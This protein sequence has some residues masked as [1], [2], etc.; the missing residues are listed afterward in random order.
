MRKYVDQQE[1]LL[2]LVRQVCCALEEVRQQRDQGDAHHIR[3]DNSFGNQAILDL[4]K[5]I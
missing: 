5:Q 2:V 3:E 4:D 1:P